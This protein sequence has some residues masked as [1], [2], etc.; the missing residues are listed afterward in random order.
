MFGMSLEGRI[1][2]W[3]RGVEQMFGY[4]EE[5][6]IGQDANSI[7][8]EDDTRD[9]VPSQEFEGAKNNGWAANVR[10]HRRK[11]GTRVFM[12]GVLSAL[13]ETDGTLIGFSKIVVDDT[14]RK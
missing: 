14:V 9:G 12:R 5:E 6:W 10:W 3:N 1:M 4:S 8:V 7:F 11:D 2:T 13:R